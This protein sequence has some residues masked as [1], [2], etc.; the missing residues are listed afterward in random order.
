MY[1]CFNRFELD[2]PIPVVLQCSTPGQNADNDVHYAL[3][4][5]D[6]IRVQFMNIGPDNI[7]AELAEYGAWDA[8]ELA[9]ED[10][11]QARILWIASGNGRD[12]LY[13]KLDEAGLTVTEIRDLFDRF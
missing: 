1:I 12:E 2:I 8:E 10:E 7:R 13:N 11:N 3:Q 9:D 5:Y 6:S 4:N